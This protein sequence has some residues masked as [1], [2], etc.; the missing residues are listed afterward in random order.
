MYYKMCNMTFANTRDAPKGHILYLYSI[1]ANIHNFNAI[2]IN[3]APDDG[4]S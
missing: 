4:G 1:Y 2:K 3:N